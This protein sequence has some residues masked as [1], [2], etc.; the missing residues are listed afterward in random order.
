MIWISKDISNHAM[1]KLSLFCPNGINSLSK[2][3]IMKKL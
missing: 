2:V 3:L 1:T